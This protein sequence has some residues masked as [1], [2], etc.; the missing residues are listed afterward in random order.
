MSKR[1]LILDCDG[2][3]CK[4]RNP[5]LALARELSCYDVIKDYTDAYLAE[6]ISYEELVSLQNPVFRSA[7]R[8]Y[9]TAKGY[10]KFDPLLFAKV[11]GELTGDTLVPAPT[12]RFLD[13]VR[14]WGYELA[15]ISSGWDTIVSRAAEE[16]RIT[17]WRANK[18]L[19][20]DGEFDGTY[21][22]VNA[23]KKKEFES[24]VQ[25]FGI[26]Y[27]YVSYLGD[28]GFDLPGMEFIYERG[29]ECLVCDSSEEQQRVSF[30]SYVKHFLS[31]DELGDYLRNS[32]INLARS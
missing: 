2:T 4:I 23:Q 18:V 30:P 1:V 31:F 3:I 12:L 5:I 10:S 29:G 16:T 13:V 25:H 22:E 21:V 24:A 9:A 32:A 7:A 15:I 27:K 28:S 17:Y 6:R 19:F 8:N 20:T 26:A 14:F 11:L